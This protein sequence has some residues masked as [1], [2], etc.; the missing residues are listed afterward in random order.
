MLSGPHQTLANPPRQI[1]DVIV[2]GDDTIVRYVFYNHREN[3]TSAFYNR[4]IRL[5]EA[6]TVE[7]Q[8]PTSTITPNVF[9]LWVIWSDNR[10]VVL[11]PALMVAGVFGCGLLNAYQ[12]GLDN[13][14]TR[15][16][17]TMVAGSDLLVTA[18]GAFSLRPDLLEDP[19]IK[20]SNPRSQRQPAPDILI[21]SVVLYALI[22]LAYLIAWELRSNVYSLIAGLVPSYTGIVFT[23]IPLRAGV[24]SILTQS[25]PQHESS[26][27]AFRNIRGTVAEPARGRTNSVIIIVMAGSIRLIHPLPVA[28]LRPLIFHPFDIETWTGYRYEASKNQSAATKVKSNE[29]ESCNKVNDTSLLDYGDGRQRLVVG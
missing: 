16:L 9:R 19:E 2:T 24:R 25:K 29:R 13:P 11:F 6:F 7:D 12:I 8:W 28:K 3:G 22:G 10:L 18:L 15:D 1:P 4:S 23:I 20:Q 26:H 14:S 5:F 27:I 21:D 17:S